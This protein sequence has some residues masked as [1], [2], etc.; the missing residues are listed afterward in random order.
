MCAKSSLASIFSYVRHFQYLFPHIGEFSQRARK[1]RIC[2]CSYELYPKI[3]AN[4]VFLSETKQKK[5]YLEKIKM[6]M[7][8]EHSFYVEPTGLAGGLSLWWSKDTQIKIQGYRK[9][10]IDAEISVKS[11]VVWF[12][13]FIYGPPYKEQ[14]K[15]FW[16]F[17]K[18]LR[19]GQGV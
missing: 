7:K 4:I 12:G 2:P 5:R 9:H 16:E 17:M 6:K 14:K 10:F 15:E 1:Q 13:T 3:P 8:L 11:E 18:N 19:N